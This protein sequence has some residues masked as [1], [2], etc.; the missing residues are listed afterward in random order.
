MK[1]KTKIKRRINRLLAIALNG[2]FIFSVVSFY[3]PIKTTVKSYTE[4]FNPVFNWIDPYYYE[5]NQD[6]AV[7]EKE[8]GYYP[9]IPTN[10]EFTLDD[11]TSYIDH[12]E[13]TEAYY[14]VTEGKIEV[15]L[16]RTVDG[17]TARFY[18][19]DGTEIIARF[20]LLDTPETKHP[21]MGVQPF[22][23]EA[24]DYTAML[25]N[26]ANKIEIE[27]DI[28]QRKDHYDRHLLY[29][30]VDEMLLQDLLVKRGLGEVAYVSAPNTRYLDI[31]E[32]S[33]IEAKQ[34]KL[35]I[36]SLN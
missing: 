19:D 3:T 14:R 17:D 33:Q 10:K 18:L 32:A 15:S 29:I 6:F 1:I 23:Q 20:L 25:L 2:L 24:S 9:P 35:G 34:N 21:K 36:W 5:W 26:S 30:W 11:G 7:E 13:P 8:E 16:S 22:G 27:Y 31:L 12:G 4:I 28:G